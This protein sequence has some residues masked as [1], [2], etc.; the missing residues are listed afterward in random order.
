MIF[1]EQHKHL[2]LLNVVYT[3][4]VAVV[5]TSKGIEFIIVSAFLYGNGFVYPR[6][7]YLHG[8]FNGPNDCFMALDLKCNVL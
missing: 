1:E 6:I 7:L 8:M 4:V 2:L 3:T 5:Y